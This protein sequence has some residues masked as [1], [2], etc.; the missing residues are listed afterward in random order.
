VSIEENIY[1]EALAAIQADDLAR[2]RDLLTRLIKR[3]PRNADYWLWMSSVVDSLRERKYC[4][5]QAYKID[6]EHE[7]VRKGLIILGELPLDEK[8]ITPPDK[9]Y[10]DW[11]KDLRKDYLTRFKPPTIKD[12]FTP[13]RVLIGL[14]ATVLV[15]ALVAIG[16]FAPGINI[17]R[18]ATPTQIVLA[19]FRPPSSLQETQTVAAPTEARATPT[20]SGPTPLWMLLEETLTPTPRYVNTPHPRAEAFR[21]GMRAFEEEKW[22]DAITYFEQATEVEPDAA[23]IY[24]YI[25]EC[26]RNKEYDLQAIKAYNQ[27][28]TKDGT[29]APAYVGL[30]KTYLFEMEQW[31]NARDNYELAIKNDPEILDAY[32]DLTLI[33]LDQENAEEALEILDAADEEDL[34]SPFLPL[35][36]AQA[37]LLTEDA[38]KALEYALL[39][40]EMDPTHLASYRVLGQS[41]LAADEISEALDILTIYLA[42]EKYDGEAYTWLGLCFEARGEIDDA[43]DAYSRAIKFNNKQPIPYLQRGLIRFEREEYELAKSDLLKS[44]ALDKHSL[45]LN[46]TLGRTYLILEDYGNAYQK[47]SE[48]EAYAEGDEDW[49][50]IYFWRAQ[51][52]EGLDGQATVARKNWENLLKLPEDTYPAEWKKIAEEHLGRVATFTRTPTLTK[53]ITPTR[54][55]TPKRTATPRP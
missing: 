12:F 33:Y 16:I 11:E 26:Y 39:A 42:H 9:L 15:L 6:P 23:D 29:F 22:D 47:I 17:T 41:Y 36:R 28:L 3:N 38:D 7:E 32:L 31:E 25:G 1:Q 18:R 19:T 8:L 13:K 14:G 30:G 46:M 40:N 35:Y 20:E 52:L 43:F 49:A 34:E 48:C 21:T 10:Q 44:H 51:A 5:R 45:I 55:P 54:T 27:A 24:Y 2:A 50:Q 53:T 4:L 37:L